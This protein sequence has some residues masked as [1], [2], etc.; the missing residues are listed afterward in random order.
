MASRPLRDRTDTHACTR[1][2][3]ARSS[4]EGHKPPL[5]SG[6][7]LVFFP[8]WHILCS[9]LGF[10]WLWFVVVIPLCWQALEE[11][12]Q[13]HT[14]FRG[15]TEEQHKCTMEF[16]EKYIMTQV[17][18]MY[19]NLD[20]IHSCSSAFSRWILDELII[21]TLSSFLLAILALSRSAASADCGQQKSAKEEELYTV[22][23]QQCT[24]H[25]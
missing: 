14:L 12:L 6:F 11:R 10:D 23:P 21:T 8:G 7:F 20:L 4:G 16:L 13:T 15:T 18:L 25:S 19:V 17:Y 24:E 3:K 2:N 1:C 5:C 9:E 22:R